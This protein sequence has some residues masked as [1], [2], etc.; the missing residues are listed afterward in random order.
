MFNG[1]DRG[2]SHT[3]PS[4]LKRKGI[5]L[6]LSLSVSLFGLKKSGERPDTCTHDRSL[7]ALGFELN[8][9]GEDGWRHCRVLSN[10]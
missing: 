9:Y 7:A 5:F 1:V 2:E 8:W 4:R 3:H 6:S 10:G